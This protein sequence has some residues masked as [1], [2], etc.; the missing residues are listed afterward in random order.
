MALTIFDWTR[1]QAVRRF[2]VWMGIGTVF[3]LALAAVD[4]FSGA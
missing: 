3:I 1:D 4:F 2:I